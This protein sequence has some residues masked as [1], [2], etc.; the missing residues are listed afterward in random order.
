MKVI[1]MT[2]AF[3]TPSLTPLA[4]RLATFT[5]G[6]LLFLLLIGTEAGEVDFVHSVVPILKE[7]STPSNPGQCAVPERRG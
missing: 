3:Q 7:N 2:A 5:A 1:P 4:H 6:C